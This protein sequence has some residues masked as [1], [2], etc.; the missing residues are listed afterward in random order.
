[1]GSVLPAE[2]SS[3]NAPLP[4]SAAAR[5]VGGTRFDLIMAILSAL[6]ILGLYIDGWSRPSIWTPTLAGGTQ[7]FAPD[8]WRSRCSSA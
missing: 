8:S 5:A 6:M 4:P 3:P 1:M 7:S 2:I